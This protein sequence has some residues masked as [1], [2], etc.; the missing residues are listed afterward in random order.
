MIF[1]GFL[2]FQQEYRLCYECAFRAASLLSKQ[3]EK[4]E[5][6]R[7]RDPIEI[8]NELDQLR[9]KKDHASE[10][11]GI[12]PEPSKTEEINEIGCEIENSDDWNDEP[13]K[14][15]NESVVPEQQIHRTSNEPPMLER[16]TSIYIRKRQLPTIH[17]T[18]PQQATKFRCLPAIV[19]NGNAC[20]SSSQKRINGR[21]RRSKVPILRSHR[22][23]LP[24]S[25]S[26]N[27]RKLPKL[28][29]VIASAFDIDDLPSPASPPPTPPWRSRSVD[30]HV[31]A[32]FSQY[33]LTNSGRVVEGHSVGSGSRLT[34]PRFP[35][36]R[37][38]TETTYLTSSVGELRV[39]DRTTR[40]QGLTKPPPQQ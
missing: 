12:T 26:S 9:T 31:A 25:R 11:I 4:S 39:I 22:I 38:E 6:K 8:F 14:D 32:S 1:V 16:L 10:I 35:L 21:Q 17:N 37:T 27:H 34:A 18:R 29:T 23:L 24:Y 19:P 15:D 13:T 30:R 33:P 3:I 20:K 5:L 7:E 2:L 40:H 28:N 36:V